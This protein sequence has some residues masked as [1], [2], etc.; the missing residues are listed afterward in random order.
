[1]KPTEH[2]QRAITTLAKN[3]CVDA[4]AG[5]GKTRVLIDRIIH[6]IETKRAEL[7]EIV[8]ITFTEKAAEE[9]RSRL[10]KA[11][12]AKA[13]ADDREEMNRWRDLERRVE[14]AHISTIHAFCSSFLREN[15]LRIGLDPDFT[16]MADAE[17]SLL[18]RETILDA[19]HA[20][21]EKGNASA[22]HAATELGIARLMKEIS[23]LLGKRVLMERVRGQHP[24]DDP[25]ALLADWR[26]IH[27]R[28]MMDFARS[29]ELRSLRDQLKAFDGACA[30]PKDAREVLRLGMLELL[31]QVFAM[32]PTDPTDPTDQ[33]RKIAELLGQL[34]NLPLEGRTLK[35]NW[36]SEEVFEKLKDL[37]D[38][39][40]KRLT[41]LLPSAGDESVERR[42]AQL[43]SAVFRTYEQ[44]AAAHQGAKARRTAFDF[45]DLIG[46][47]LD[48]LRNNEDVRMRTARRIKHLM[49]DEFQDTDSA[50]L[51]IAHLLRDCA[52][53]P[54]VFI[55]GDAKQSIYD[56]RGA[57]VEVFQQQ[58]MGGNPVIPLA[59]NFRTVPDVLS[60]VNDFFSRSGLLRAVE[61]SYAPLEIHRNAAGESRIEFLIP[62]VS[63]G[64]LADDYRAQEA[65]VVASRLEEMC[66]GASR[67]AVHDS[68]GGTARPAEFGDVAILFRSMDGVYVYERSLR[69]RDIPY[70]VVAGAGFYERQEVLDVRN[71]LR[72]LVD[73]WDESALLGFLRGPMAAL[74]DE[75]LMRLCFDKPLARAFYAEALID[76]VEASQR[77]QAARAL[78]TDLRKRMGM[79]LPTFLRYVLDQTGYEAILLGQFLG[80]QKAGNVRKV[81]DLAE[82]FARTRPALLPAFVH[83]LDAVR[84]QLD[85]REGDAPMTKEGTGAVTL[86]TIHKAKGLEFPIV[87]LADASRKSSGPTSSPV[88]LH[89][90]FGMATQIADDEGESAN[91]VVYKAIQQARKSKDVAEH[92]RILYVAMTRARDWLLIGSAPVSKS[93]SWMA[94]L[95]AIYDV[96]NRDDGARVDGEGWSAIV[97]RAAKPSAPAPSEETEEAI[98]DLAALEALAKPL[99]TTPAARQTFSVSELLDVM[100]EVA[101]PDPA[102]AEEK[103]TARAEGSFSPMLRGTL[104]HRMFEL[105]RF[106][107]EPPIDAFLQRECSARALRDRL[108]PQLRAIAERFR[109]SPLAQRMAA[110]PGL[111]REVP[112]L[113]RVGDALVNGTLDALLSDGTIVDYKTGKF[114]PETQA[115]YEWQLRLYAAAVI[116]LTGQTPPAAVLCY[117]DAGE[118]HTVGIGEAQVQDALRRTAD[119][120]QVLRR[121]APTP[122]RG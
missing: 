26:A 100:S 76:D 66:R 102:E 77:L 98:P 43:T 95:D 74:P 4:G 25:E 39:L 112:F 72:V 96:I 51:E 56:F 91:P 108:A 5:S 41:D 12:R 18:R 60:F 84:G 19:L 42:A 27:Q 58:K 82:D 117:V 59:E 34:R 109:K 94:S 93:G 99:E 33:A 15:A 20:L 78:I 70:H 35:K 2:Q 24:L 83:Y 85:V 17:A 87:V 111:Q 71:L 62:P 122:L 3:L 73:P 47:T 63:D 22:L 115:R 61:P 79:P 69:A 36:V 50:Q 75:A 8:A 107:E 119:A 64:A 14:M 114:A 104:V 57:E 113:L 46:V 65:E 80:V 120:I 53:G 110:D 88:V 9:M 92:A 44:A 37:Q 38:G 30:N 116:R 16:V 89:R 40:K 7:D 121:A 86:M 6:L 28:L 90:E 101:E 21:L 105:W 68:S 54:D 48:T 81:I 55:V 10:R 67:A 106:G 1:M 52:E 103:V 97:R 23:G 31:G 11:F 29:P 13:P 118:E 49:I 32:D 45:D